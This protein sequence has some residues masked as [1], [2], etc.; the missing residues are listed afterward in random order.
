M[1][2]QQRPYR[3]D[4]LYALRLRDVPGPQI[5]DALA[6]VDSHVRESGEDPR[7]AFGAPEAYAA[8]VCAALGREP[9]ETW[10]AGDTR[11]AL[12]FGLSTM[13]GAWLALA[14]VVAWGTGRGPLGVSPGTAVAA[15]LVVLALAAA[16]LAWLARHEDDPVRDPRDGSDL[17][18]PRPW[19]VLPLMVTPPALGAVLALVLHLAPN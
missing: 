14:G 1:T 9:D 15:G 5:A 17:L 2:A 6:E 12:L 8:Q 13:A 10:T 16:G 7:E 18:P 11:I 4:L 19:W 3:D